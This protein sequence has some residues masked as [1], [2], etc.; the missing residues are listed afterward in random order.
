MENPVLNKV[1][2][3]DNDLKN[4]LVQ[5]VGKK[6]NPADNNVT[7]EMV[8]EAMANEFPEFV[9]ALAEENWIRG[10]Q[11]GLDDVQ[12]GKTMMEQENENRK[13]CKLCEDEK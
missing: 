7:I 11:Q 10:Y 4:L 12:V 9:M 13:S 1:V 6:T 3:T 5:H 2:Q 8:I